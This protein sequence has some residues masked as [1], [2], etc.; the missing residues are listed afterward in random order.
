MA[1]LERRMS[2]APEPQEVQPGPPQAGSVQEEPEGE[3]LWPDESAETA[4]LAERSPAGEQAPPVASRPASAPPG[5]KEVLPP[6]EDLLP[7]IPAEAL[8]ALDEHFRARFTGVRRV[9]REAL[10]P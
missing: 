2:G 6:L 4:F 5:E 8:A 9:P 7:R 3:P 10:K 1:E